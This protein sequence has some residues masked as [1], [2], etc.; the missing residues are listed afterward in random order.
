MTNARLPNWWGRLEDD[1]RYQGLLK[2]S[3]AI[4]DADDLSSGRNNIVEES[5][6]DPEIYPICMPLK[7]AK[8]MREAAERIESMTDGSL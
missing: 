1:P 3:W 4:C 7:L 8:L 5:E 2:I 6:N